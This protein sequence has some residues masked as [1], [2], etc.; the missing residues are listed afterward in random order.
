MDLA[1]S[2]NSLNINDLPSST[3]NFAILIGANQTEIVLKNFTNYVVLFITQFNKIGNLYQ[4]KQDIPEN[5][6]NIAE[7][8]Y[9]ITPLIG[10]DNIEAEAGVRFIVGKLNIRKQILICL[11]LKNYDRASLHAIVEALSASKQL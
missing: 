7:P 1:S 4:V 11:S 9:T 6:L 2:L 8:V 10:S 5:G 3:K